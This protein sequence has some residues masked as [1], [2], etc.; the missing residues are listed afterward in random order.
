MRYIDTSESG[1]PEVLVVAEG[2]RP[3]PGPISCSGKGGTRR[4]RMRHPS[5]GSRCPDKLWLWERTP[6]HGKSATMSVR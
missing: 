1:G 4:H 3:G 6:R 2:P 5:L